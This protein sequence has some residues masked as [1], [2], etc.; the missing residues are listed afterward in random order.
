MSIDEV[1]AQADLLAAHLPMCSPI[2]DG[3]RLS[4]CAPVLR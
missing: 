1:L 4:S 3:A 2:S